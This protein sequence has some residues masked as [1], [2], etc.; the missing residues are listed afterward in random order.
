MARNATYSVV[1]D[2]AITF[3]RALQ[4]ARTFLPAQQERDTYT[5][6]RW[7]MTAMLFTSAYA[8]VAADTFARDLVERGAT[9]F[10]IRDSALFT[11]M[12]TQVVDTISGAVIVVSEELKFGVPTGRFCAEVLVRYEPYLGF[13]FI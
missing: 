13:Q 6:W 9:Q 12:T 7:T 5:D 1:A 2:H 3:C 8:H 4:A 10:C 11:G